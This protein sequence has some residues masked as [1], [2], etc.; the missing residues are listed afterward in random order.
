MRPRRLII[1]AAVLALAAMTVGCVPEAERGSSPS[2]PTTSLMPSSASPTPSVTTEPSPAPSLADGV[3]SC[4]T[5]DVPEVVITSSQTPDEFATQNPGLVESGAPSPC[6]LF[7]DGSLVSQGDQW[8]DG[9]LAE[10][11]T[12]RGRVADDVYTSRSVASAE[13]LVATYLAPVEGTTVAPVTQ[14]QMYQG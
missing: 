12:D 9:L 11:W 13:G 7:A 14:F 8:L 6:S 10:G 1:V 5:V 4:W 3:P 2:A